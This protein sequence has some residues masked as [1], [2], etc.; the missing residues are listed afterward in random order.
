[1][2]HPASSWCR[3]GPLL[4]NTLGRLSQT[5]PQ[6]DTCIIHKTRTAHVQKTPCCQS[7]LL[8]TAGVNDTSSP[9]HRPLIKCM[10]TIISSEQRLGH[11]HNTARATPTPRQNIHFKCTGDKV[12]GHACAGQTTRQAAQARSR[13]RTNKPG[14]STSWE[15]VLCT[16]QEPHH[17]PTVH[18]VDGMCC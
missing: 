16:G 17:T 18:T 13:A 15:K 1:M 6:A 8:R 12:P 4:Q 7:C 11:T 2:V 10:C 3:A 14:C 9:T 5:N